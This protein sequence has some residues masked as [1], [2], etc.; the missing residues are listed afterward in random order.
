M[1]FISLTT[2]ACTAYCNRYS[3]TALA[4]SSLLYISLFIRSCSPR[5]N[6]GDWVC[7]SHAFAEL[8]YVDTP[9]PST[10]LYYVCGLHE[11]G[12]A[13]YLLK[14][15]V[16][17]IVVIIAWSDKPFSVVGSHSIAAVVML[18][19]IRSMHE[20]SFPLWNVL[21]A[22]GPGCSPFSICHPFS[23]H[24]SISHGALLL[25]ILSLLLLGSVVSSILGDNSPTRVFQSPHISCVSLCGNS[26]KMSCIWLLA[27]SSSTPRRWR[28]VDGG[29]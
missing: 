15:E 11:C 24:T 16:L 9:Y 6:S 8:A 29:R 12:F 28:L 7:A 14:D 27:S 26:S 23:S 20:L 4:L 17:S 21:H 2:Y 13:E 19:N 25:V 22:I 18:D 5:S 1:V 10:H 3:S